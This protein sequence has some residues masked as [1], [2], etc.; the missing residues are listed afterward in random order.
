MRMLA[1]TI[2]ILSSL[3]AFA[4]HPDYAACY[5]RLVPYVGDN[6]ADQRCQMHRNG[7]GY[8]YG[9]VIRYVS[10]L[11]ANRRCSAG[12][13]LYGHC[14]GILR[15]NPRVT[16]LMA[17]NRCMMARPNYAACYDTMFRHV[18]DAEAHQRCSY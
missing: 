15:K 10:D 6:E 2:T 13:T 8:C 17:N 14:Y 9:I 12:G 3:T 7:Y 18:G 1:L 5:S 4:T 11:A 16:D